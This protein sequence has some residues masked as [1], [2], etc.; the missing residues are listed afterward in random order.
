MGCATNIHRAAAMRSERGGGVSHELILER[1]MQTTVSEVLVADAVDM[2]AERAID[3][4]MERE[5][6]IETYDSGPCA[7]FV[8]KAVRDVVVAIVA[9]QTVA[10]EAVFHAIVGSLRVE[11]GDNAI[12]H[13]K[14]AMLRKMIEDATA[15]MTDQAAEKQFF[16]RMGIV[17]AAIGYGGL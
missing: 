6:F 5:R 3:D 7:P 10:S 15:D 14:L 2:Y 11:E 8:K 12:R 16:G 9:A 4:E 13:I 17:T 1:L